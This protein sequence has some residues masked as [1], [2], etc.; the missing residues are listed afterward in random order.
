MKLTVAISSAV[1]LASCA[2][3]P[4][5]SELTVLN[6]IARIMQ[7]EDKRVVDITELTSRLSDVAPRVRGRAALALGRIGHLDAALPLTSLLDDSSSYVRLSATFALGQL[8]GKLPSN[9]ISQLNEV[10]ADPN[11]EVQGRAAQT[12]GRKG[13]ERT[14]ELVANALLRELPSGSEI[15][16]WREDT[17]TSTLS[18]TYP[19]LRLALF[20]LAHLDSAS[21]GL[22]A[23]TTDARM[24]RFY[25]WPAA[26]TTARLKGNELQDLLEEYSRS[27]D[28]DERIWG[29]RGLAR[30]GTYN[31]HELITQPLF[32]PNEKVRIQ[33]IRAVAALSIQEA[34]VQMLKMMTTDTTYVRVEIL[35]ALR[36]I[37]VPE[38]VEL[39]INW[40]SDPSPWVR[41]HAL[42]ALAHQDP[43]TFWLLLSGLGPD[44]SWRIRKSMVEIFSSMNDPRTV[45]LLRALCDDEDGRVRAK[46]ITAL[47][48][49]NPE[50]AQPLLLSRLKAVDAYERIA[51]IHS[52]AKLQ[53]LDAVDP[54]NKAFL[55]ESVRE[56][57]IAI[58]N[59]I[60]KLDPSIGKQIAQTG[61]SDQDWLVRRRA[62]A[63][64]GLPPTSVGDVDI[65]RNISMYEGLLEPKFTPQAFIQ[66][67]RGTIELELF[68]IDAPLTV[69][70]FIQLSRDGYYNGLPFHR[71]VPNF[72]IQTGDPRGKSNSIPSNTIRCEINRRAFIRGTVGMALN[73]KDTGSNQ[74]FITHLPQPHLDGNYTAFGQV[75]KGMEVVDRI[76]PDDTI[77]EIAI[78][79]GHTFWG[80]RPTID[81][82]NR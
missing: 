73:G 21:E 6:K 28:A 40:I 59:A 14:A 58:L 63:I 35:K 9:T 43:D 50:M 38:A 52:L 53:I 69:A 44:P 65:D 54:L 16:Q 79:D 18:P 36:R 77:Q 80:T 24:L 11:P 57:K 5:P 78:W 2:S 37:R 7:M 30:V 49:V 47:A 34:K 1:I 74:F 64:A 71:V 55:N 56:V 8:E 72:V 66:T 62:V 20:A 46:A 76:E 10:L 60:N 39:L 51:A 67:G 25:W 42:A 68:V 75:T 17:T 13:G 3:A 45:A 61:A 41:E 33:A 81:S 70:N 29:L 48:K 32:D 22:R 27:P 31:T 82:V 4:P 19:N 12:L 15:Y 23:L 26:W